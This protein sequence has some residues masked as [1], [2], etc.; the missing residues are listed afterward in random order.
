[1][2]LTLFVIP[3]YFFVALAFWYGAN[4]VAAGEMTTDQVM[5]VFLGMVIGAFALG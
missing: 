1:M 4:R 5:N 2:T 3:L